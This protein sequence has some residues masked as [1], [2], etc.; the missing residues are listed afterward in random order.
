[1][2][3]PESKPEQ[4]WE[5]ASSYWQCVRPYNNQGRPLLAWI[6]DNKYDKKVFCTSR[7]SKIKQPIY[8]CQNLLLN[9][10]KWILKCRHTSS[11]WNLNFLI[12]FMRKGYHDN[13][14]LDTISNIKRIHH[15]QSIW[16]RMFCLSSKEH[17]FL[18]I[19]LPS[20]WRYPKLANPF[21]I[22]I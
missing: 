6:D 3:W 20:F 21:Y 16:K 2:P 17:L 13:S 5:T 18:R 1:M 12:H 14:Y 7:L 15:E 4:W 10:Y 19:F 9:N 8:H 11:F 22:N